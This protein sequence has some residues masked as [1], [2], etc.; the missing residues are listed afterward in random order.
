MKKDSDDSADFFEPLSEE[1]YNESSVKQQAEEE[2]E[3]RE[4]YVEEQMDT[5]ENQMMSNNMAPGGR[6]G[7]G[8]MGMGGMGGMGSNQLAGIPEE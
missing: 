6:M 7:P 1:N 5:Q 3:A 8:M 4:P 2:D